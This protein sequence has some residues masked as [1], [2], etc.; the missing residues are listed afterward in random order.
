MVCW[1]AAPC[2]PYD[3]TFSIHRVVTSSARERRL[4]RLATPG[5]DGKRISYGCINVPV[6]FYERHVRPIFAAGR[7]P[8]YVLP[9]LKPVQQVFGSYDVGVSHRPGAGRTA[10]VANP[11]PGRAAALTRP[12]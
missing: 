7:A 1:P 5:V 11:A 10:V 3:A 2:W 6:A 4:L 12:S 9:E 8:V